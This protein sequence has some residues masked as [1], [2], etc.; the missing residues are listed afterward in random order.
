M[1]LYVL[2]SLVTFDLKKY[3]TDCTKNEKK[4]THV[5]MQISWVRLDN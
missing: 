4:I 5:K 2:G 1:Y 3:P